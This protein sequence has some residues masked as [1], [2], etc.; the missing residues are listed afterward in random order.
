MWTSPTEMQIGGDAG[1]AGGGGRLAEAAE[2]EPGEPR[3]PLAVCL[4]GRD[5]E[6]F[7]A[8]DAAE[9][10]VEPGRCFMRLMI[11]IF[12][13]PIF[14][15]LFGISTDAGSRMNGRPFEDRKIWMAG[16]LRIL[17]RRD[18]RMEVMDDPASAASFLCHSIFLS[19]F[20]SQ[21][22]TPAPL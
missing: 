6:V 10:G 16:K 5:G 1:R 12:L 3:G 8:N 21:S 4:F 20:C 22:D 18:V 11:P 17:N 13:P 14:L 7:Q 2:A 9:V 15:P 19:S